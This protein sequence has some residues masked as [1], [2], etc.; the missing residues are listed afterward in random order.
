MQQFRKFK[1]LFSI[2]LVA[3][4]V[5]GCAFNTITSD[6]A[7]V[8]ATDTNN[9]F[10]VLAARD[11]V[12]VLK[13]I[14]TL[15]PQRTTLGASGGSLSQDGFS[16]E[17]KRELQAAGYAI[18]F[19][20]DGTDSIPVSFE[21][22]DEE[23]DNQTYERTLTVFAGDVA[24]RR[25]YS[26]DNAGLIMPLG[27]MQVRGADAR[28]LV[29]DN[30]IFSPPANAPV[31]A[32]VTKEPPVET[33]TPPAEQIALEQTPAISDVPEPLASTSD[34]PQV[35]VIPSSEADLAVSDT[36]SGLATDT[37]LLDL[38]APSVPA[39]SQAVIDIAKLRP[40]IDST[41]NFM[42]LQQSNFSDLFAEMGIVREKILTF[43]NDSTFMGQENKARLNAILDGFNAQSD[44][45][46]VIGC[47]MG[48]TNH[49]GGQ[50]ALAKGRALRVRDE[51]LYAG[52]P[53]ENILEEGCWGEEA[54]DQRMPR[55]GV[56]VTL[57]RRLG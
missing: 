43:P 53:E 8:S 30:N 40:V 45:L 54:F 47:S 23:G 4:L 28:N 15:A 11:V 29:L 41:E 12:S 32:P 55:R 7:E 22:Q 52:I 39:P 36:I 42:S 3:A 16:D 33:V 48:A 13:Q 6:T 25:T 51:L 9:S 2:T 34:T 37:S 24:V 17:L 14:D 31:T 44:V 20:G 57:K 46:S 26:I 21:F 19:V 50:E 18:R 1:C 49:A 10:D 27:A 35:V 38:V 56:V 5:S